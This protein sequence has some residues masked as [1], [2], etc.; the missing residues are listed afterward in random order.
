MLTT[1]LQANISDQNNPEIV[2]SLSKSQMRVLDSAIHDADPSRMDRADRKELPDLAK[3]LGR[4]NTLAKKA[5]VR[6]Q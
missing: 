3:H 2:L 5:A 4:I 6:E 1:S